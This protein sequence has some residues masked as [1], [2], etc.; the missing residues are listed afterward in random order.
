MTSSKTRPNQ[1]VPDFYG[2][3]YVSDGISL[4]WVYLFFYRKNIC[5][6][7]CIMIIKNSNFS[8][9]KKIRILYVLINNG[10]HTN[11]RICVLRLS[12][13]TPRKR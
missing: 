10:F 11:V 5:L 9:E 4:G 13:P 3:I 7:S 8:R 2:D 6:L 12:F 1:V